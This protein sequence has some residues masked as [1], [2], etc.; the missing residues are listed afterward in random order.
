VLKTKDQFTEVNHYGQASTWLLSEKLNTD[1]REIAAAKLLAKVRWLKSKNDPSAD[2]VM[3]LAKTQFGDS[4][5]VGMANPDASIG[6]PA[7]AP[8]PDNQPATPP[9][10]TED[11]A[12]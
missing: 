8:A 1:S 2:T 3:E 6:A 7:D 5:L 4:R 12:P 10:G 9:P 11:S